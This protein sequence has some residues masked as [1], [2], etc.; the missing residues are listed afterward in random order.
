[1]FCQAILA[2]RDAEIALA[3]VRSGTTLLLGRE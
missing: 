2:E 1:L 3:P